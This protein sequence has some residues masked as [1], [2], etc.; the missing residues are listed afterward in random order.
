M[1]LIYHDGVDMG[2]G[3]SSAKE[4]DL[5]QNASGQPAWSTIF[6]NRV[7]IAIS[8]ILLLVVAVS[9]ASAQVGTIQNMT[10]FWTSEQV[11]TALGPSSSNANITMMQGNLTT[12][13]GSITSSL[14][15][16]IFLGVV[17]YAN[18]SAAAEGKLR[19]FMQTPLSPSVKI[20]NGSTYWGNYIEVSNNTLRAILA[21]YNN[22]L[23][24]IGSTGGSELDQISQQNAESR[25]LALAQFEQY[26]L[27]NHPLPKPLK[28]IV[29]PPFNPF[30]T[31]QTFEDIMYGTVFNASSPQA[32]NE[33][34]YNQSNGGMYFVPIGNGS[35]YGPAYGFTAF[36]QPN[37]ISNLN[38]V[39]AYVYVLKNDTAA[40]YTYSLLVAANRHLPVGS[41]GTLNGVPYTSYGISPRYLFSN[42][43][44]QILFDEVTWVTAYHNFLVMVAYGFND[45]ENGE[46]AFR[47]VGLPGHPGG[48][49]SSIE[50]NLNTSTALELNATLAPLFNRASQPQSNGTASQHPTTNESSENFTVPATV[51]KSSPQRI[52]ITA[53]HRRTALIVITTSSSVGLAGT[54][55]VVNASSVT[56]P[57][58]AGDA[59]LV[60]LNVSAPAE[61]AL[62]VTLWYNCSIPSGRVAPFIYSS[63][64]WKPI[65][66]FTPLS[67][68][69]SVSFSLPS[70]PV[71]ALF[72]VAASTTSTQQTQLTT[73]LSSSSIYY[74]A[75]AIIVI[76]VMAA[77]YYLMAKKKRMQ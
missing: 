58:P 60:A 44:A 10:P 69:C 26:N 5:R 9:S 72:E 36:Y 18:A 50:S 22:Y 15:G 1:V 13:N 14:G 66:N 73:L 71:F 29:A 32:W 2:I 33:E 49:I 30:P 61:T 63:G 43:G 47:M 77:A 40:N 48:L 16:S 38:K 7:P 37:N 35:V 34:I 56:P 67:A 46:D 75:V 64:V 17:V 28:P 6:N 55:S 23:I 62:N 24:I 76:L 68:D 74:V 42:N 39:Q 41:Y 12:Y 51:L 53:N 52:N 4:V 57:P 19:I 27:A 65:L 21:E 25:L 8:A 20:V 3:M 11:L 54:I 70:D 59:K 31:L 45:K